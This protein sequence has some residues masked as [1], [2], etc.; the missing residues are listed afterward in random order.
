MILWVHTLKPHPLGATRPE[1][2]NSQRREKKLDVPGSPKETE[3]TRK[4]HARI[5]Q[6]PGNTQLDNRDLRCCGRS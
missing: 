3:E 6:I 1:I 4:A 2:E 5:L